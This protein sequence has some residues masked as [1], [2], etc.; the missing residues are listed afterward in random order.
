MDITQ[1]L[2]ITRTT[3]RVAD[4]LSWQK[5]GNLNLR[6]PFQRGSV[7][8]AKAKSFF[9]DTLVKGFPVPLLFIQDKTDPKT[10][11]PKR[12]VVDGQQRIRTVLAFIDIGCLLD[13]QKS[14]T[15]TVLRMHNADLAGKHFEQLPA[16]LR[17]RILNFQFSVQVL[18]STAPNAALLEIFARMNATGT[19]LNEQELRNA[20][21]AGAFKQF[22][23]ELAY[24]QFDNW[25]RWRIFGDTQ[26]ARMK[27]VEL[28]SEL[29]MFLVEGIRAKNQLAIT[30][31]YKECDDEFSHEKVARRRLMHV[32]DLLSAV[33]GQ[34]GDRTDRSGDSIKPFR[35]QSWFYT[36]FAFVHDRCFSTYFQS[37]GATATAKRVDRDA[38]VR[39]VARRAKALEAED[40]DPELLKALR[41]ASTDKVSRDQ[42]YRFLKRNWKDA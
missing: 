29:L 33:F 36:L 26:L 19:R 16:Y 2:D 24:A 21:F 35:S 37:A 20:A 18:P 4:F 41:G 5:S 38:L 10:Y 7:W 17:E 14:D 22:A 25:I 39:H 8:S 42:R 40:I 3:Y 34:I 13:R 1:S 23:Y 30:R 31:T 15:F 6:P 28:T 12:L 11:E 27:E 9:I 32:F